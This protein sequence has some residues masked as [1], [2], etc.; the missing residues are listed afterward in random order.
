[1]GGYSHSRAPTADQ[2]NVA[3][4]RRPSAQKPTAPGGSAPHRVETSSYEAF[5]QVLLLPTPRIASLS[6]IL[7][8]GQRMHSCSLKTLPTPVI[9]G[10]QILKSTIKM[11][12]ATQSRIDSEKLGLASNPGSLDTLA[13]SQDQFHT[14]FVQNAIGELVT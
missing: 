4:L 3:A 6:S 14:G 5:A 12:M 7:H 9:F 13:H 2:E 1:M 10:C 11:S 8:S